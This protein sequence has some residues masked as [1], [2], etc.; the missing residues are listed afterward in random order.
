MKSRCLMF[1][2]NSKITIHH[3]RQHFALLL[4]NLVLLLCLVTACTPS[5][6]ATDEPAAWDS[7]Q[8]SKLPEYTPLLGVWIPYL[9]LNVSDS[10]ETAF[11]EKVETMFADIAGSGFNAIFVHVRANGDACY[12]S[13]YFPWA[14]W[15]SGGSQPDYDP[16]SLMIETA[17][18]H[19]LQFHAWINPYRISGSISDPNLLP[20]GTPGKGWLTDA[21]PS[22][23]SW[24]VISGSGI[25]LNP[26]EPQ[27][28]AL[29]LNGI[30]EL[31]EQYDLDGIHFDDYFYPTTD[32]A[33]DAA[34]YAAY[35]DS[36]GS[37][38][39]SLAEW[40]RQNVTTLI[41]SVHH[42]CQTAQIPFGISPSAD[43]DKNYDIYYADVT[44]WL[45]DG[46]VDYLAPQLYFGYQY[47]QANYTYSALLSA[48]TALPRANSTALYIGLG[49]YKIGTEDVGT[50]E[51]QLDE[52]LLAQQF[53]DA[54]SN[55]T[56]GIIVYAYSSLF[57][58]DA[59][60]INNL[61]ALETAIREAQP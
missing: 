46:T 11:R 4:W 60:H 28:Q 24:A 22:N 6:S 1:L 57:Q 58:D 54:Q 12:P 2:H 41:Q 8:D 13:A 23:D 47:P 30:R 25:Y 40:R 20:D 36:S 51:W 49:A 52:A 27:V 9:D 44:G 34:T 17:K 55:Q 32:P 42:L 43:I 48:W 45:A 37:N 35:A 53:W 59:L 31:L 16:L 15:I 18:S 38:A 10:S 33:F 21:D 3:Q 29:V 5:P 14:T 26:A 39:M 56:D 61:Q 7:F 19:G 50:N